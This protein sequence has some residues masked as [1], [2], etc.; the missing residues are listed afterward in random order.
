MKL[1]FNTRYKEDI[2]S[3]KVKVVTANDDPARI[4]C[5]DK[6]VSNRKDII[7]LVTASSTGNEYIK[8]YYSDGTLISN[9]KQDLF[10]IMPDQWNLGV[11]IPYG[12]F[13]YEF[14]IPD[15]YYVEIA[16]KKVI[17]RERVEKTKEDCLY[18]E[19]YKGMT[20]LNEAADAYAKEFVKP[21]E[22][23]YTKDE[24]R[25]FEAQHNDTFKEGA[26][27]QF[28]LDADLGSNA[29]E[30]GFANGREFERNNKY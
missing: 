14:T 24:V 3:G 20:D 10:V 18:G 23:Y 8:E 9:G 1:P 5:W 4:I 17:L 21:F 29:Y 12:T 25:Q 15:G 7:A 6:E 19:E 27:W 16:D 26:K 11:D 2:L 22:V 28:K 30:R 13:R